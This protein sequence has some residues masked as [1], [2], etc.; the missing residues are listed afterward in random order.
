MFAG[1]M[2]RQ[3]H[4]LQYYIYMSLQ[5]NMQSCPACLAYIIS[6]CQPNLLLQV[7][8]QKNKATA[9]SHGKSGPGQVQVQD[10]TNPSHRSAVWERNYH[11]NTQWDIFQTWSIRAILISIKLRRRGH[12]TRAP[13]LQ[14]NHIRICM[15]VVA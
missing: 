8:A 2:S 13:I 1:K 9:G 3:R 6:I 14:M 12:C 15:F 10:K 4:M 5:C 11:V 7:L